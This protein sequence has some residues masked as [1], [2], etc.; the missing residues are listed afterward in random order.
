MC[1][2]CE[3]H[4]LLILHKTPFASSVTDEC[5]SMGIGRCLF[6]ILIIPYRV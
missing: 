5:R 3:I 2:A 6:V 1:W 4:K